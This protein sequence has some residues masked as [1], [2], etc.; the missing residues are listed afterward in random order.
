[1]PPTP[2]KSEAGESFPRK[3]KELA[4]TV[5]EDMLYTPQKQKQNIK[6]KTDAST[7]AVARRVGA[8]DLAI[9][10]NDC[11]RG[12]ENGEPFPF[13]KLPGGKCR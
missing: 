6:L 3:R 4:M 5:D 2:Q 11:G 8:N 1:M 12:N 10:M 7:V 13:M 9:N